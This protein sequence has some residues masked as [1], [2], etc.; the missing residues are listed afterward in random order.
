MNKFK[1]IKS[2]TYNTVGKFT[3]RLFSVM[4]MYC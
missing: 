1:D 2:A 4:P 3:L